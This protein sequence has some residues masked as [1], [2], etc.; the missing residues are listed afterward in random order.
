MD[1]KEINELDV[2]SERKH[3]WIRTRFQY[4]EKLF[5][6]FTKKNLSVAEY[7][8]G[9]GQNLWYLKTQSPSIE[10]VSRAVGIDPNLPEGFSGDWCDE[11][12]RLSNN[13]NECSESKADVLLAMDV[14]EHVD[15]D[16]GVLKQWVSTMNT[17][18]AILITV[19]AFQSLWSY[20]D[21]FLEHRKRYTKSELLEVAAKAGLRPVYLR[22]AFGYLFPVVYLVRKLSKGSKDQQDLKLPNPVINWIMLLLGKIE[23]SLGGNPLFGTSVIGIFKFEETK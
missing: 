5:S 1:I 11:S 9:S 4:I 13:L 8:C 10:K 12:F 21:E 2:Q 18:G 15:D 7:G 23:K 22:Y 3:W 20:H 16:E 17:D 19:P 14:L 6:Y